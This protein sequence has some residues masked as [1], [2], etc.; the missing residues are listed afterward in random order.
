MC[1]ISESYK[2]KIGY[3]PLFF[4]KK[5]KKKKKKQGGKKE[6]QTRRAGEKVIVVNITAWIA[7]FR[8]DIILQDD[9]NEVVMSRYRK[10]GSKMKQQRSRVLRSD[11]WAFAYV[12]SLTRRSSSTMQW[13]YKTALMLFGYV[14]WR[15]Q[16]PGL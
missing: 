14:C 9:E 5:K 6:D 8:R 11:S 7:F 15:T 12:N 3:S 10:K 16:G 13:R 4:F 1:A 2:P